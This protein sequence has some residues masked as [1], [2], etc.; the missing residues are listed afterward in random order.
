MTSFW[1]VWAKP[2]WD[3][4]WFY[5]LGANGTDLMLM[6][7]DMFPKI[8]VDAY[9]ETCIRFCHYSRINWLASN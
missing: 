9:E 6:G 8:I 2:S 1:G 3:N 7:S 4:L 5:G